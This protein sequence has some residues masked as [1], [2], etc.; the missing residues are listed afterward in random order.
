MY[1]RT[2]LSTVVVVTFSRSRTTIIHD[3]LR[4]ILLIRYLLYIIS[5]VCTAIANCAFFTR[6]HKNIE[7]KYDD[8]RSYQNNDVRRLER[9]RIILWYLCSTYCHTTCP[10]LYTLSPYPPAVSLNVDE[11]SRRDAVSARYYTLVRVQC[12]TVH[13]LRIPWPVADC[14]IDIIVIIGISSNPASFGDADRSVSIK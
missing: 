10:S 12:T 2:I 5:Y 7:R 4:Y 13:A 8:L 14:G 3:Y 11:P 6:A 1:Y 9:F